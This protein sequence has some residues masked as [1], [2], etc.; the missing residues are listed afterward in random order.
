MKV[1]T[2]LEQIILTA[3]LVLKE[4]AYGVSIS[5]KVA[6]LAGKSIMYGSLYN[7]LDQLHKKG[8]VARKVKTPAPG[9]GG[10]ERVLYTV[11]GYGL[12]A[13]KEARELQSALWASL[14]ALARKR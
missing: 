9:E 3:V 13:L 10:H 7:V 14:P 5:R 8:Y 6:E 4:E 2:V 1:L 11:T 12:K